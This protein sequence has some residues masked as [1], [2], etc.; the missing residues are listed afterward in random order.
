M[1]IDYG[2]ALSIMGTSS[3]FLMGSCARRNALNGFTVI[4][5][6]VVV[7][8]IAILALLSL[9]GV[10]KALEL[11]GGVKESGAARSLIT[12]YM[13]AAT[14]NNGTLLPGYDRTL[15]EL[16]MPDG[17]RIPSPACQRYPYRLAPYFNYNIK[18]TLLTSGNSSI[19]TSDYYRVSAYPSFGI[20]YI[21]VGGDLASD[22]KVT[23]SSDCLQISSR[24]RGAAL[25]VFAT[26]AGQDASGAASGASVGGSGGGESSASKIE[27]YC[28]LEPP[29]KTGPMWKTAPWT[30]DSRPADYGQVDAR[31]GGKAICA[32]TDGSVRKLSVEELRDM[33]LWSFRAA[34]TDDKNYSV[35][36]SGGRRR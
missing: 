18:N 8:I 16:E 31:H 34:D 19:K 20:N 17:T 24:G 5:L 25:V 3:R 11:A 35:V 10:R 7:T 14:D 22:G 30:P 2:K 32:L 29:R 21:F 9:A 13:A 28:L 1:S 12:A 33:R 23:Y 6:L 4:E 27:G 26:A 15:T 36:N